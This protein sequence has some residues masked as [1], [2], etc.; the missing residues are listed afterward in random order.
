M[1][2]HASLRWPMSVLLIAIWSALAL[3]SLRVS[4]GAAFVLIAPAMLV[5]LA[6]GAMQAASLRSA[7]ETFRRARSAM[8]VRRAFRG[9]PW[10]ARYLVLFWAVQTLFLVVAVALSWPLLRQHEPQVA[11]FQILWVLASLYSG[12][13]I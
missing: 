10:G 12:F 13:A 2:L 4:A 11:A 5:G 9:T 3:F 8:D 7:P 6:G 1:A